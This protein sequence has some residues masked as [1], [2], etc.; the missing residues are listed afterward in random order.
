M[1]NSAYRKQIVHDENVDDAYYRDM[2]RPYRIKAVLF[3]FDGTL[4]EPGA[5]DF[6]DMRKRID[7]PSDMLILEYIQSLTDESERSQAMATVDACE[8]E[9]AANSMPNN[10]AERLLDEL[11]SLGV[12]VGIIT[13]NSRLAVARSLTNFS[14]TGLESFDLVISR[15]DPI[16]PKPKPDGV[17]HAAEVWDTAVDEIL[18]VGDVVFDVETAANA[19]ALSAFITNGDQEPLT[20]LADFNIHALEELLS[21]VKM[22]LP[23]QAGKLPQELL[24]TFLGEYEFSDSSV[25]SWPGIGEDT[26][27]V[28]AEAVE[29][30][31]I[32]SDPI[33]FATDA[34][35]E[36]AVLV[37]A[38]DI[39][40][41]G[42]TPRWFLTTLLFPVD[43]TASEIRCV[44]AE[45]SSVCQRAG[46]TLCGGHTEITDGVSRTIVNGMMVGSVRKDRFLDKKDMQ[47]GDRVLLTKGVAIEGTALIAR[48]F[49]QQLLEQGVDADTIQRA[50]AFLSRISVL[51]EGRIAAA[52]DG[53]KALHDI[54][55]GGIATALE[56]FSI[57][58]GFG[59]EVSMDGIPLLPETEAVCAPFGIDP[60]GL[61]GSG[62]LL[63][64]CRPGGL[65]KLLHELSSASV[66]VSVIGTVTNT[67]PGIVAKNGR[68]VVAWPRFEVDEITRLFK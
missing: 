53:V 13:R 34:I 30:I 18:V 32:T 21:I 54:T 3:D 66:D 61:I 16:A 44:M 60:L 65:E 9:A 31:V 14:T 38:N 59:I 58:G 42:G 57:A 51:E 47:P 64:C 40:T 10:G 55:E 39:V 12:K 28:D 52:V 25:L 37:N 50:Q 11:K 20:E 24:D 7:C 45:L 15:D 23:L 35:G 2:N 27:A 43:T 17:L 22:G 49:E 56:E 62:S 8:M 4:T 67:K 33:T 1:D 5:I 6:K 19:G 36:Y 29:V 41:S 63:I 48:E 68:G 46:I 26:A